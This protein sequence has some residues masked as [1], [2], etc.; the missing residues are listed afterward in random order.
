MGSG[1]TSTSLV[2]IIKQPHN[3][4]SMRRRILNNRKTEIYNFMFKFLKHY[5]LDLEM[6]WEKLEKVVKYKL[7]HF[8]ETV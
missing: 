2:S 4:V 3:H 5:T 1:F 8:A 6:R 7:D